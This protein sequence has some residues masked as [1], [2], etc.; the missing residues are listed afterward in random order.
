MDLPLDVRR[1][2][3]IGVPDVPFLEAL[4]LLRS[5]QASAWD[6]KLVAQRLFVT[7]QRAAELLQALVAA[8]IAQVATGAFHYRPA[9]DMKVMLDKL[10]A[11]YA[12]DLVNVTKLIHSRSDKQAQ[13]FA[14]AFR[15]RKDP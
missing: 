8:G 7:E 9:P 2:I 6:P 12:A 4:L 10:A 13:Q 3:L 14:D 1:F 5:E 11:V 15:L